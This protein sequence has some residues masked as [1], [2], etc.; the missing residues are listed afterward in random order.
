MT[1]GRAAAARPLPHGWASAIKINAARQHQ[2]M[3]GFGFALTGGSADLI[4]Q[5][6]PTTRDALLRELFLFDNGGIGISYLQISI[7]A[8]DLSKATFSLPTRCTCAKRYNPVV[9]HSASRKSSRASL[10][11]PLLRCTK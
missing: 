4:A 3:D 2:V 10:C 8:S 9:L 5:L 1:D 6:A 7:G 11:R